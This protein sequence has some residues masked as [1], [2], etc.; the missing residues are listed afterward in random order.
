MWRINDRKCGESRPFVSPWGFLMGWG[1]PQG[2]R[3][4]FPIRVVYVC[5]VQSP[6]PGKLLRILRDLGCRERR[7]TPSPPPTPPRCPLRKGEKEDSINCFPCIV[8]NGWW[9][10]LA[11]LPFSRVA[12]AS[13]RCV[14]PCVPSCFFLRTIPF[15]SDPSTLPSLLLSC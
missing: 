7:M 3:I 9:C 1:I 4:G 12:A 2:F 15:S 14:C 11:S 6:I 8:G 13:L 5:T 10:S